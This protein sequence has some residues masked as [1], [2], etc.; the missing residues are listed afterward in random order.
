MNKLREQFL[1]LRIRTQADARAFT[2]LYDAYKERLYRFVQL[3]VPSATEAED[4]TAEVFIA[5]WTYLQS[6]TVLHLSGYLFL[7]ARR[8]IAEFYRSRKPDNLPIEHAEQ[9]VDGLGMEQ[10]LSART[11]WERVWAA[12]QSLH[13]EYREILTLRFIEQME[14]GEI[15]EVLGKRKN[16]ISVLVHRARSALL[17]AL[18]TKND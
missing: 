1:L 18:G 14:V 11:E 12:L 17:L 8:R 16:T 2:E 7:V 5:A 9:V 3:K 13:P 10:V 4:I 6:R 15:A